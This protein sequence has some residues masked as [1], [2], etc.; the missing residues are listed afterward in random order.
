MPGAD[1]KGEGIPGSDDQKVLEKEGAKENEDN[2]QGTKTPKKANAE[3]VET[4]EAPT[5]E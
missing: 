2:G 4:E 5:F 3:Q 1:V